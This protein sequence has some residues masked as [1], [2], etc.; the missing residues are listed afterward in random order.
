MKKLF[1]IL[2]L[3]CL[4]CEDDITVQLQEDDI[5]TLEVDIGIWNMHYH[6]MHVV[7]IE[8]DFFPNEILLFEAWIDDDSGN[9]TTNLLTYNLA[10]SDYDGTVH[11]YNL[12][13]V[14]LKRHGYSKYQSDRYNSETINRGVLIIKYR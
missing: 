8:E 3:F 6:G 1:I 14:V 13:E 10:F 9:F 7:Y 11:K 2:V 12:N 4:S 5:K